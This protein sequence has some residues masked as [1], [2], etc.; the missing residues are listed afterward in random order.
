MP[1]SSYCTYRHR[2]KRMHSHI[3]TQAQLHTQKHIYLYMCI[4]TH[5]YTHAHMHT[6]ACTFRHENRHVHTCMTATC[7]HA[8]TQACTHRHA[9]FLFH[10]HTSLVS[11]FCGTR[12]IVT[13]WD[14]HILLYSW[15]FC[16][17]PVQAENN[18]SWDYPS[19]VEG[20]PSTCKAWI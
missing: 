5:R 6:Q 20:G 10:M 1:T 14:L 3:C 17:P 11:L 16:N 7:M 9:H 19:V 8:C 13:T 18:Q 15:Y 2:H 4:H 12:I